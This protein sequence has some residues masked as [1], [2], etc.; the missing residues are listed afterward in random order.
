MLLTDLWFRWDSN[1]ARATTR[2][3]KRRL[4]SYRVTLYVID[5][6]F[7]SN[8]NFIVFLRNLKSGIYAITRIFK[9]TIQ[10]YKIIVYLLSSLH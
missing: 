6:S 8:Q 9:V 10:K 1:S 5:K 3:N 2:E 7:R 4:K